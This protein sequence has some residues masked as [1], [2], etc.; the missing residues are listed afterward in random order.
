MY[1]VAIFVDDLSLRQKMMSS[2]AQLGC[3]LLIPKRSDD[4]LAYVCSTRPQ[5]VFIS[6]ASLPA[7]VK[8]FTSTLKGHD[9]LSEICVILVADQQTAEKVENDW[10]IDDAVF[11]P[12]TAAEIGLRMKLAMWRAGQPSADDV[13]AAGRIEI[14]LANYE[15][16][17]GGAPVVLTF[18]EYELLKFLVSHPGRVQTRD[19][20][21][22][23][24]WGYDYYGGTRTVDV[25]VRRL[26][27]KLGLEAAEHVET[28]RN[29][30]YRFKT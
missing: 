25:H 28:V 3:S 10:G 13:L 6:P 4:W 5:F 14:D 30:G 20:L 27:E 9:G 21:L 1:R 24:V 18:K 23:H 26:R 22:N 11:P 29:V 17:V 7:G 16:K 19:A 8:D 15:V 12:F 2:L